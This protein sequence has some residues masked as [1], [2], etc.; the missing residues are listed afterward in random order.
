MLHIDKG[1]DLTLST[2]RTTPVLV[3]AAISFWGMTNARYDRTNSDL[4]Y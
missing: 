2:F 3:M 1:Y 4:G